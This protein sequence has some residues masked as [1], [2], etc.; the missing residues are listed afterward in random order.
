[1]GEKTSELIFEKERREGKREWETMQK[2]K[3][4]EE[5]R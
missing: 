1:M 4:E 3:T 2:E 5:A